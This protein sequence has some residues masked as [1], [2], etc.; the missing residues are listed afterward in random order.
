LLVSGA[1]ARICQPG[2]SLRE[3]SMS[4][5]EYYGYKHLIIDLADSA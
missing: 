1:A 5:S 3:F 2:E 4:D